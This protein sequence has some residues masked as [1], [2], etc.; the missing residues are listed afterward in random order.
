VNST[1]TAVGGEAGGS[2]VDYAGGPGV[3]GGGA[4]ASSLILSNGSGSASSGASATGGGGG[5]SWMAMP[6]EGGAA[7]AGSMRRPAARAARHRP[8]ARP[9]AGA[10][11][12]N[13]PESPAATEAVLQRRPMRWRQAA[14][15]R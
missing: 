4:N 10:A 5:S 9:V 6:G 7:S 3:S 12:M 1:A 8:R 2:Y 13:F 14:E 11:S 15:R